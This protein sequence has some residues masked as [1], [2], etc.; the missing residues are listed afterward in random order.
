MA[1][2]IPESQNFQ[3]AGGHEQ[4]NGLQD[5]SEPILSVN[6]FDALGLADMPVRWLSILIT[7]T[8]RIVDDGDPERLAGSWLGQNFFG[9]SLFYNRPQGAL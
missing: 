9:Q 8:V 5:E 1:A 3:D 6:R 7:G 2:R 4:P